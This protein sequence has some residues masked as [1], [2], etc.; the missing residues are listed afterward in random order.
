MD[1][2]KLALKRIEE[3]C[4]AVNEIKSRQDVGNGSVGISDATAADGYQRVLRF[5][6][7]AAGNVTLR[8]AATVSGTVAATIILDGEVIRTETAVNRPI[9][10]TAGANGVESGVHV[11]KIALSGS[12]ASVSGVGFTAEGNIT[13]DTDD[14]FIEGFS[15]S[16][17]FIMR[18]FDTLEVYSVTGGQPAHDV[19]L[20]GIRYARCLSAGGEKYVAG[21]TERGLAFVCGVS[22][23]ATSSFTPLCAGA[24]A[25]GICCVFSGIIEVFV[26]CGFEIRHYRITVSDGKA[27]YAGKIPLKAEDICAFNCGGKAYL[28]TAS[29]G[30]L[31]LTGTLPIRGY[32]AG[33]RFTVEV[34]TEV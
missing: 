7:S 29:D 8:F 6:T 27:A 15:G 19:T 31:T 26:A 32:A 18:S 20:E 14:E 28:I 2:G 4:M 16:D 12:G 9:N 11:A 21:I 13:I 33:D 25:I 34:Q 10:I 3:L 23:G 1:Y 24:G 17:A 22:G 30:Y 5:R